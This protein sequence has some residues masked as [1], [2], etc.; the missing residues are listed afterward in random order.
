MGVCDETT[1]RVETGCR[2]ARVWRGSHRSD[3]KRS[4]GTPCSFGYS[5]RFCAGKVQRAACARVFVFP[6]C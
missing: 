4:Q 3:V 6:A 5:L 1:G 2:R